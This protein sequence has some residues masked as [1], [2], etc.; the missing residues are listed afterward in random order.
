MAVP[1][2]LRRNASLV[3]PAGA[4]FAVLLWI[5]TDFARPLS[6]E[7]IAALRPFGPDPDAT[8][9]AWRGLGIG[10]VGLPVSSWDAPLWLV[11][12][13]FVVLS[14]LALVAAFRRWARPAGRVAWTAAVVFAASWVPLASGGTVGPHLFAALSAVL[15]AG[16]ATRWCM[17]RDRGAL[18]GI[19]GG[20]GL[21]TAFA[22]LSGLALALGLA[23]VIVVWVR[24]RSL[25]GLV[26]AAAGALLGL[27]PW[28]L[29]AAARFGG[30]A[31]RLR[32]ATDSSATVVQYLR[33]VDGPLRDGAGGRPTAGAVVWVAILAVL[34][35][36]GILQRRWNHRR[37]ASMVGVTVSTALLLPYLLLVAPA[38]AR[39]LLPAYGLLVVA[40][41]AGV[42]D[43]WHIVGR[44]IRSP[45]VTVG[46]VALMAGVLLWQIS[47]GARYG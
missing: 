5:T 6:A 20:V 15:A 22:P 32:G 1:A 26:S 13:Y 30:V 29:E 28:L 42:L 38:D 10:V 27:L 40:V 12:A 25:P 23:V 7:E 33:L 36:T 21:T 11:R 4:V 14:S 39:L 19:G 45:L 37:N 8:F 46:L 18:V 24:Q 41:A 31:G 9:A 47:L 16:F 17:E 2:E 34:A 44:R 3:W 35:A 43:V